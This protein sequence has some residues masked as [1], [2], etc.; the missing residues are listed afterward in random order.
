MGDAVRDRQAGARPAGRRAPKTTTFSEV[1]REVRA[2]LAEATR[3]RDGEPGPD[4]VGD[5]GLD[6]GLRDKVSPLFRF[7]FESYWRVSLVGIDNVPGQG[8]AILVGNHSGGLPFDGAMVS[9]AISDHGNGRVPRPLYARF[10]EAI[11]PVA[12]LYRK[13]GAVPARYSV[14]DELLGRGELIVNFPEGVDGI[15]KLYEDRYQLRPFSSSAVRLAMRHRV[16]IVPFAVIGAEE[17]YPV[18][19]RSEQLG[20]AIGAPFVPVTP[21]FPLLGAAGLVP[22]PTKW[23]IAFGKRIHLYREKRFE[24]ASALDFDAMTK[25]VRRTVQILVRRYLAARSSIFLG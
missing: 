22:L 2:A 12:E 1:E 9:Y 5:Y 16:P 10:V 18:I 13:C 25:R 24:G 23:T 21:F 19:G 7:L 3:P 4:A 14:A 15:G 6:L 8:P 20:K 11:G 17:I